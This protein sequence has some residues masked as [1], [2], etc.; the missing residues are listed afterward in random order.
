M[1]AYENTARSLVQQ[2]VFQRATDIVEPD[3]R[4]CCVGRSVASEEMDDDTVK[5]DVMPDA[6]ARESTLSAFA[7]REFAFSNEF[8]DKKKTQPL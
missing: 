4:I 5:G 2:R 1:I 7:P 6:P 3:N 8:S